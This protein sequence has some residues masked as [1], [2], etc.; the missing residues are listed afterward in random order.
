MHAHRG[1]VWEGTEAT[2]DGQPAAVLRLLDLRQLST[3]EPANQPQVYNCF[4]DMVEDASG[5]NQPMTEGRINVRF[6]RLQ[7]DEDRW[8]GHAGGVVVVRGGGGWGEGA[9]VLGTAVSMYAA[10]PRLEHGCACMEAR[11]MLMR[12]SVSNSV[13]AWS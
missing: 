4:T 12:S 3:N 11:C 10:W 9:W 13:M 5:T 1:L 6:R 8:V 7:P 2:N